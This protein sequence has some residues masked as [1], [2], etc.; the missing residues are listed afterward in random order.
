MEIKLIIGNEEKT[1]KAPFISARKLRN[2]LVISEKVNTEGFNVGLMDEVS[3]F[4]VEIYGYK[5]TSDEL[6][7]GYPSNKFFEKALEDMNYIIQGFDN[8]V[9]N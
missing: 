6:L 2:T 7:D 8:S 4:L 5:F 1:F 3:E 9:K